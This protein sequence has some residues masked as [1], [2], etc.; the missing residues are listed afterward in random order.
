M[1]FP[2]FQICSL[3]NIIFI[4]VK[5]AIVCNHLELE[6]KSNYQV[7]HQ[8]D[9]MFMNLAHLMMTSIKTFCRKTENC[10]T[11]FYH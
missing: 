8:I 3:D 5:K 4:T 7:L 2:F 6:T 10:N 1:R 9:Q 11:I